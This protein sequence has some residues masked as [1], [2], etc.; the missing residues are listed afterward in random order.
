MNHGRGTSIALRGI[1]VLALTGAGPAV[2]AGGQD[3]DGDGVR[4]V[5]FQNP[6]G[7]RTAYVVNSADAAGTFSI[8]DAGRS[9]ACE[10]PAGAVATFT[11]TP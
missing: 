6:D 3:G 1:G 9:L 5:V 11:W 4:N 10:L 7:S 8:T 2:T